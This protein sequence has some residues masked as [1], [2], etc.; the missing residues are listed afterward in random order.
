MY[1]SDKTKCTGFG[2]DVY[3]PAINVAKKIEKFSKV[4]FFCENSLIFLNSQ[5]FLKIDIV[6]SNSFLVHVL[7]NKNFKNFLDFL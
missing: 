5:N 3:K 6:F 7:M 4:N 1:I 2:I